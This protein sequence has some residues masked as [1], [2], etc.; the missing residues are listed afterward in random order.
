MQGWDIGRRLLDSKGEQV[1]AL[2]MSKGETKI[3]I[4]RQRRG[5]LSFVWSTSNATPLSWQE[6]Q[7]IL[8]LQ[9]NR[10]PVSA[11]PLRPDILMQR[12]R[13]VKWPMLEVIL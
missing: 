4:S 9:S 8:N 1:D 5:L 7:L 3:I 12:I 10:H 11:G 13:H 6:L 2:W